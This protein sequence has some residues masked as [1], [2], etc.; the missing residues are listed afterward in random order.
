MEK[1]SPTPGQ[2]LAADPDDRLAGLRDQYRTVQTKEAHV[3]CFPG[4]VPGLLLTAS[5]RR[6]LR[7]TAACTAL[8]E[9][10]AA[11]PPPSNPCLNQTPGAQEPPYV[12]M[13]GSKVS[14]GTSTI[15][16]F[17]PVCANEP[18]VILTFLLL[19]QQL[20]P[21]LTQR[22][23]LSLS[24]LPPTVRR[25]HSISSCILNPESWPYARLPVVTA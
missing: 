21:R 5:S 3:V 16:Q 1:P 11:A 25:S 15:R 20:E 9:T 10:C 24:S 12:I 7:L 8:K 2:Q 18:T 6:W 13:W 19:N 17:G 4:E 23:G 14:R 22:G